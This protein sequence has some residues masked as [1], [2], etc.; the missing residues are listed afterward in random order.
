MKPYILKLFFIII[1]LLASLYFA[2]KVTSLKNSKSKFSSEELDEAVAVL[3]ESGVIIKNDVVLNSKVV[4]GVL[5]L[6]FDTESVEKIASGIMHG[7]YGTFTVPNGQRFA[8]DNETFSFFYDY[9]FEYKNLSYEFDFDLTDKFATEFIPDDA[10]KLEDFFVK[11]F[12]NDDVEI[13]TL[14]LSKDERFTHYKAFELYRGVRVEGAEIE[15]VFEGEKLVLARGKIFLSNKVAEYYSDALDSVNILFEID[16]SELEIIDMS[17]M[18]Y[19]VSDNDNSL[20]FTPNYK[21][22][23]ED[24]SSAVYD[25]T[26]GIK[27]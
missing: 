19:Q 25:A 4:P 24:G 6:D 9:T 13:E 17:L 23:Y 26:S 2:T 16:K 22:I 27:K 3:N 11:I 7:D 8:S 10:E 12:K 1:F 20:Y 18:Y 15:A 14:S 5:K 21:F